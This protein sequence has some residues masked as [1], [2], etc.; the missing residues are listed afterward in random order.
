MTNTRRSFLRDISAAAGAGAGGGTSHVAP[1]PPGSASGSTEKAGDQSVDAG[2]TQEVKVDRSPSIHDSLPPAVQ[3]RRFPV[4][5][6]GPKPV[7]RRKAG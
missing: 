2:Q 6:D 5:A 7:G 3:G 4:P 1:K